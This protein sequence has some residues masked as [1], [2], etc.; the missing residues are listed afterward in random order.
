[1]FNHSQKTATL[2]V[3]IILLQEQEVNKT[4]W[5][6]INVRFPRNLHFYGVALECHGMPIGIAIWSARKG[7]ITSMYADWLSMWKFNKQTPFMEKV[8]KEFFFK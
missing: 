7:Q 1:L 3:H 8:E 4:P 5:G 2:E 6:E